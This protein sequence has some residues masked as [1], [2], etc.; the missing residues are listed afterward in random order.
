MNLFN[1]LFLFTFLLS[2]FLFA[3][4]TI[5]EVPDFFDTGNEGTLNDAVQLAIDDGTLS[6]TI[7]KLKPLWSIR[8]KRHYNYSSG[9]SA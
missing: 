1:R 8:S 5:V 2:S 4:K 7:F 3:Q 6:S 9:R